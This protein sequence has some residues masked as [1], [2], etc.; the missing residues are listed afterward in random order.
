MI[1]SSVN[2]NKRIQEIKTMFN[3]H[4]ARGL[5]SAGFVCQI[6]FIKDFF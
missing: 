1:I 5:D 6:F 2:K 4:S 3:C